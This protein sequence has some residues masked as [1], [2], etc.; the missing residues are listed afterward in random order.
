MFCFQADDSTV[1]ET[2]V[3]GSDISVYRYFT[4]NEK[5]E[6]KMEEKGDELEDGEEELYESYV[7][8][9]VEVESQQHS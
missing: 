2:D 9:E 6:I 8:N 7:V 3:D 4:G 1:A 5:S